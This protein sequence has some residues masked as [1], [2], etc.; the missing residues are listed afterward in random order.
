MNNG[1]YLRKHY[2]WIAKLIGF[3]MQNMLENGVCS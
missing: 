3:K 1:E 2:D